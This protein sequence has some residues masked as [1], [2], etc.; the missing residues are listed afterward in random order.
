MGKMLYHLEIDNGLYYGYTMYVVEIQM[1]RRE[2][3]W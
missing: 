1:F 2:N 3:H